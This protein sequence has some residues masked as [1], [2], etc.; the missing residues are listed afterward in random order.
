MSK[1]I[2]LALIIQYFYRDLFN[3][4]QA[5]KLIWNISRQIT[6]E[7][8]TQIKHDFFSPVVIFE[9]D[10]FLM[11]AIEDD[12]FHYLFELYSSFSLEFSCCVGRLHLVLDVQVLFIVM[13]KITW[14]SLHEFFVWILQREWLYDR[15]L[16][17]FRSFADDVSKIL[18][19]D[20]LL[21][22]LLFEKRDRAFSL[23]V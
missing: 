15:S 4:D 16:E 18:L 12:S 23:V 17:K 13:K 9:E 11:L 8:S 5:Y 21:I 20:E 2:V 7:F 1:N 10:M 3:S 14:Y 19:V 22:I 6:S